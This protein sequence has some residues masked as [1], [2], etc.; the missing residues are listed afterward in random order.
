LKRAVRVA[1]VSE[2]EASTAPTFPVRAAAIAAYSRAHGAEAIAAGNPAMGMGPRAI[3]G[4]T[5]TM[6]GEDMET[7]GIGDL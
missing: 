1:A 6:A 7:A 2:V 5:R 4:I 3:L